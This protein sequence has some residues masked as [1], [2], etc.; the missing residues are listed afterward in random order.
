ML[1]PTLFAGGG[2]LAFPCDMT[3]L[4]AEEAA[5]SFSAEVVPDVGGHIHEASAFV[6]GMVI[7]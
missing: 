4:K 6:Q 7:H 5:T 1:P 3:S 2:V